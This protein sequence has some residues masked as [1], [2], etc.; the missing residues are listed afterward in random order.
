M[1]DL[2]HRLS[3]LNIS[4]S[5]SLDS[6]F[7]WNSGSEAVEAAIKLARH[8]T[9]KQNIIAFNLGYHGR[10]MGT[11]AL[12][13]SSTIY[14]AGF[15]PLMNG[16][17]FAQFPYLLPSSS[18]SHDHIDVTSLHY[19]YWGV[20]P[21]DVM[22]LETKRCL[23]SLE[24]LLRT[25]TSPSET[26][27]VILEPIL[28]EGGYIPCPPGF[29]KGLREVCTKHGLLLIADEVQT[30]F[31]RTGT[32][33]ACEWIDNGVNPD[34]IVMAKGLGNGFPISAM[35]SRSDLTIKQTPGSMGGTYGGNAV[36]CAAALAVLETFECENILANVNQKHHELVSNLQR[37]Q[38]KYP[39]VIREIRGKGLMIGVEFFTSTKGYG[40][41]A[42]A[43]AQACHR[44][45][46]IVLSCG[47]FDTIRFIPPLNITSNELM[48][49]I[50]IF[51]LAVEEYSQSL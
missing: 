42:T 45:D 29:L 23:D 3:C 9:G 8:S 1:I 50:D 13:S 10:T 46:L 24:L 17:Y 27:A 19:N 28:G 25:Q 34:I 6:W 51:E 44:R 7:L 49:G 38:V 48:Q 43:I 22:N 14:R 39:H 37:I 41:A 15:G 36:G 11:M 30:G 18:R 20:S 32:M 26:A 12:T 16:V 47:P 40:A 4:K 35:G 31:G 33:F 5:A 21:L 2:I